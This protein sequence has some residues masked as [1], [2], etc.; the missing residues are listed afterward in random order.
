MPL[1]LFLNGNSCR[2]DRHHRLSESSITPMKPS[3]LVASLRNAVLTGM[4]VLGCW[5]AVYAD[6][7]SNLSFPQSMIADGG[8]F[9]F[10]A[11]ANGDP[12][13]RENAGFISKVTHDAKVIDLHFIQGGHNSVTLN[14]PNGMAIV[15]SI[16]YVADLDVVRF[17]RR[18][19][20]L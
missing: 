13:I 3:C 1:Q 17:S 4:F 2:S 15:G 19:V 11:N 10:I 14:S 12:G 20:C 16:L 5:T 8:K 7:V 9:Y 6:E 18:A